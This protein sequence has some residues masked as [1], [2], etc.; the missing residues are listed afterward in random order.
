MQLKENQGMLPSP[1][2]I[3]LLT[4]PSSFGLSLRWT[5]GPGWVLV[6]LRG[7]GKEDEGAD[8]DINNNAVKQYFE[9][10]SISESNKKK[11][12]W[13]GFV[14]PIQQAAQIPKYIATKPC[15]IYWHYVEEIKLPAD[16]Y[17]KAI[18]R[19]QV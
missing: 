1:S 8:K 19:N 16:Y 9:N 13:G 6:D 7:E 17:F 15:E 2:F 11:S 12:V 3:C 14:L 4:L 5:T 18:S 10:T